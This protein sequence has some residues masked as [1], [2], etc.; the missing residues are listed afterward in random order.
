VH[1]PEIPYFK[2]LVSMA[3]DTLDELRDIPPEALP[4]H[5]HV[6]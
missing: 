5:R 1:L 3:V 2:F 6:L 4:Y